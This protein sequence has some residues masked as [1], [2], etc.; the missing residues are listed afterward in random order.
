[1]P[2]IFLLIPDIALR[3]AVVEQIRAAK[4]GDPHAL[5]EPRLLKQESVVVVEA[6]PELDSQI[7]G[8]SGS[9]KPIVL[10][11]GGAGDVEGLSETFPKPFRL[12]HLVNRLRYY[13]ETT[14]LLRNRIVKFGPYRLESQNRRIVRDNDPDAIRLTEKETAL[15]VYL[16]QSDAPATR[17]EILAYVW[18]YDERID[19][20]T[21]ETHIYQLRRK[22][23]R[24]GENWIVSESGAY[25]LAEKHE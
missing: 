12:G 11:L 14:P 13:L 4:L 1:M 17:R 18:G 19:T 16:A 6:T 2:E 5:T 24:E 25:R 7:Q 23:D 20:H 21:L 8:L 22:L 15:L 10:V 9:E 3:D